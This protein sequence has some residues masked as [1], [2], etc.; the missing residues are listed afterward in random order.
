MQIMGLG[1]WLSLS[2]GCLVTD[3]ITFED[4]PDDPPDIRDLPTSKIKIGELFLVDAKMRQWPMKV[5]VRDENTTRELKAHYRIVHPDIPVDT[6]PPPFEEV[7][8]PSGGLDPELREV[9]FTVQTDLLKIGA[10]H[11]LELAVSGHFRKR[12]DNNFFFDF[13]Q[14]GFEDDLDKVS[15]WVWEGDDPE[16]LNKDLIIQSCNANVDLLM[17]AVLS[18]ATQ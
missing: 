12:T 13:P 15:W 4:E 1:L 7:P 11:R 5:L 6:M 14:D 18:E 8:V 9:S 2:G 10:C 3:Q 16:R 17:P